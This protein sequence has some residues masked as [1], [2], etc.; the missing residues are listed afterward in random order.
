[1]ETKRGK[2]NAKI[3]IFTMLIM[4][5]CRTQ[6]IDTQLT[7]L[8]ATDKAPPLIDMRDFFKNPIQTA[9]QLSP[10]GDYLASSGADRFV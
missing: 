8:A 5:G 2:M 9:H 6:K 10:D 4:G 1:M 3:F 7:Q